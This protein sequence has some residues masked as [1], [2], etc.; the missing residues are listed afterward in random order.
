MN[1]RA[2]C[3]LAIVALTALIVFPLVNARTVEL[4]DAYV[5]GFDRWFASTYELVYTSHF[6]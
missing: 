6:Y 2:R 5:V 4:G 3:I 1:A